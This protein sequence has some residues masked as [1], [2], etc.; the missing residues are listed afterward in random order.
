M[1]YIAF[2]DY[3]GDAQALMKRCTGMT[4]I[5]GGRKLWLTEFGIGRNDPPYGPSR[6]EQNTYLK[7]VQP[8][9]EAHPNVMRYNWYHNF[10]FKIKFYIVKLFLKELTVVVHLLHPL[11]RSSIRPR[12]MFSQRNFPT[13]RHVSKKM[14]LNCG[15][16]GK[17]SEQP[18]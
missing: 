14:L 2:H 15:G 9:L 4:K 17:V 6:D 11:P 10:Y 8:M 3:I 16:G 13:S 18:R 5:Y 1:R 7:I 12:K